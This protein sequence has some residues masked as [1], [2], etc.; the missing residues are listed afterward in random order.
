MRGTSTPRFHVHRTVPYTRGSHTG[1]MSLPVVTARRFWRSQGALCAV[2]RPNPGRSWLEYESECSQGSFG[3]FPQSILERLGYDSGY[4][5]SKRNI[6]RVWSSKTMSNRQ[7]LTDVKTSNPPCCGHIRQRDRSMPHLHPLTLI[8]KQC[9]SGHPALQG[10]ALGRCL[11]MVTHAHAS[12]QGP[13]CGPERVLKRISLAIAQDSVG[14]RGSTL[15]LCYPRI[16]SRP[17][18]VAM[19]VKESV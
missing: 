10:E 6:H 1:F 11:F 5:V 2:L 13:T 12:K 15:S 19:L 3:A 7:S 14:I 8:S 16:L 4:F 17:L 9:Q 18:Q